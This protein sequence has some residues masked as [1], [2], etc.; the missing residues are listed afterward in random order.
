MPKSA[1]K[2][3]GEGA[4]LVLSPFKYDEENGLMVRGQVFYLA[5]Y[6]NDRL[7][8]GMDYVRPVRAGT[9]LVEC[10]D[11]GALFLDE[12]GRERHG[13]HFHDHWCDCGW[14]PAVGTLDPEKAL[15]EHIKTCSVWREER[16][17]AAERHLKVAVESS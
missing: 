12:Y 3:A 15:H 1:D 16:A 5:G 2:K 6:E 9:P 8:I 11:C 10:G 17:A 13:Q 14:R 4:C 7:L